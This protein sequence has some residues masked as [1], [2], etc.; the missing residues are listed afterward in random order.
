CTNM[1]TNALEM[2]RLSKRARKGDDD[3]YFE[4]LEDWVKGRMRRARYDDPE[5]RSAIEVLNGKGSKLAPYHRAMCLA[6]AQEPYTEHTGARNN[7]G[8]GWQAHY[9]VGAPFAEGFHS[10]CLRF[11]ENHLSIATRLGPRPYINSVLIVCQIA[12][13]FREMSELEPALRHACHLAKVDGDDAWL[14][15]C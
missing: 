12:S 8:G 5:L 11:V 14:A 2:L 3:S 15:A 1:R 9:F 10:Y 7:D 13:L 4:F 6:F